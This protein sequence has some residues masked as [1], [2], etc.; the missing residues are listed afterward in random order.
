[1]LCCMSGFT[2]IFLP[3]VGSLAA[4]WFVGLY[5]FPMAWEATPV[6]P[7]SAAW[8]P[9]LVPSLLVLFLLLFNVYC[10]PHVYRRCWFLARRP[11]I[12]ARCSRLGRGVF[13]RRGL[14]FL[15]FSRQLTPAE[16][17]GRAVWAREGGVKA[18]HGPPGLSFA[19]PTHPVVSAVSVVVFPVVCA[20]VSLRCSEFRGGYC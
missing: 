14:C 17:S 1:M 13:S 3:A 4:S 19:P 15:V 7:S 9:L 2:S 16:V 12:Q 5:F 11:V 6:G 18:K 20:S 8:S 10:R